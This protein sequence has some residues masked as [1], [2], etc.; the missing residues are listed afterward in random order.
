MLMGI[1]VIGFISFRTD[2]LTVGMCRLMV[3]SQIQDLMTPPTNKTEAAGF[4]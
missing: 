1:A 2:I 3:A 4:F